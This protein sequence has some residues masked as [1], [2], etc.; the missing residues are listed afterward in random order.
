MKVEFPT[1][2]EETES[3]WAYVAAPSAGKDRGF[4]FLPDRD[5]EV[6]VAF[7]EGHQ[8][9]PIVLGGVWHSSAP[10]PVTHT[11]DT[12][13][14]KLLKTRKHE[15]VSTT[16]TGKERR[17]Q[18]TLPSGSTLTLKADGTIAVDAKRIWS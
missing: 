3:A 8:R 2:G 16:P 9:D 13:A 17:R 7:L 5:D 4:F 18:A 10:A 1:T 15:I 12:N 14:I 11:D 6:I